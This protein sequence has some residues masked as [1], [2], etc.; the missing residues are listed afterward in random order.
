MTVILVVLLIYTFDSYKIFTY[1]GKKTS[2]TLPSQIDVSLVPI[3]PSGDRLN[4]ISKAFAI[5]WK[6]SGYRWQ[7]TE[8]DLCELCV[9]VDFVEGGRESTQLEG[10]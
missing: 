2:S 5:D 1:W 7:E 3:P 4:E 8:Y 10:S 6:S 9:C